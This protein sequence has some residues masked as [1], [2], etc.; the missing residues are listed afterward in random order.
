MVPGIQSGSRPTSLGCQWWVSVQTSSAMQL[1]FTT[2][3]SSDCCLD[4]SWWPLTQLTF[5]A[6]G[7]VSIS[8][9]IP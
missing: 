1:A 4:Q 5:D 7:R 3:E 6:M 9:W 2:K 8:R